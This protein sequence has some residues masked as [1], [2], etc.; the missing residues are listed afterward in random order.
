MYIHTALLA[1]SGSCR[2]CRMRRR[3]SAR[4]C[5]PVWLQNHVAVAVPI[6]L[7][8]ALAVAVACQV[9]ISYHYADICI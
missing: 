1:A 7:A 3:G 2:G 4:A 9:C 8:L 6:I 5:M